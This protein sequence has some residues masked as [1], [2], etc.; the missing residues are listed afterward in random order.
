MKRASSGSR[1]ESAWRKGKTRAA[2]STVRRSRGEMCPQRAFRLGSL[3]KRLHEIVAVWLGEDNL[4]GN[5]S[6]DA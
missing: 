2:G 1:S 5:L 4:G 6:R 3:E